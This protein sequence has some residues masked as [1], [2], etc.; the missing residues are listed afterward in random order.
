MTKGVL[1]KRFG[2]FY[3]AVLFAYNLTL[4]GALTGTNLETTMGGVLL[5]MLLVFNLCVPLIVFFC[6]DAARLKE[7]IGR[8]DENEKFI[9]GKG[10]DH[11][12]SDVI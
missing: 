4:L 7:M 8:A 9:G 12:Y 5:I 3:Y 6:Y 2:Y 10:V 11:E 1:Y